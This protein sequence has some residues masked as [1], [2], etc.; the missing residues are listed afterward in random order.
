MIPTKKTDNITVRFGSRISPNFY[1][2]HENYSSMEQE[3]C[4]DLLQKDEFLA[5][6]K[7]LP[8]L[9]ENF[10]SFNKR[11]EPMIYPRIHQITYDNYI[12][13][14]EIKYDDTNTKYRDIINKLKL[15][16]DEFTEYKLSFPRQFDFSYS[17]YEKRMKKEKIIK[18]LS[19]EDYN[20]TRQM[21][22]PLVNETYEQHSQK[23]S[24][25][26]VDPI[27]QDIFKFLKGMCKFLELPNYAKD[28]YNTTNEMIAEI[29]QM[30]SDEEMSLFKDRF[31]IVFHSHTDYLKNWS[32]NYSNDLV[33][34][35][36]DEI[37]FH[38]LKTG[39]NS[40][41]Q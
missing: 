27:P 12:L 35:P 4:G 25:N 7:G 34:L 2:D 20:I 6:K 24:L 8:K 1:I 17:A 18:I 15:S 39:I 9:D 40:N 22:Y 19:E 36:L 11:I 23:L 37:L 10:Y 30:M 14:I 28:K 31:P 38:S 29:P 32:E 3:R 16:R 5:F 21:N 26:G 41:R 33:N 13:D